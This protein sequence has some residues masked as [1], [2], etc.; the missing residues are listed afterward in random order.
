ML[1]VEE[2]LVEG[3]PNKI[4]WKWCDVDGK[5][6]EGKAQNK[7]GIWKLFVDVKHGTGPVNTFPT[8]PTDEAWTALYGTATKNGYSEVGELYADKVTINLPG[9]TNL[10]ISCRQLIQGNKFRPELVFDFQG[11]D[12]AIKITVDLEADDLAKLGEMLS[13]SASR[14][15]NANQ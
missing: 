3:R 1:P 10:E 5:I 4:F 12:T 9:D 11:E 15:L 2:V 13:E 7:R 14:I 6:Q 8:N